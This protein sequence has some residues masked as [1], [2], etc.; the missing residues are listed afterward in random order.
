M[1][2]VRIVAVG[3]CLLAG[4]GC[5]STVSP[6][7]GTLHKESFAVTVPKR[8]IVKQGESVPVTISLNRD[9]FFK[10]NVQ[11]A[12]NTEGV[13][14]T[15]AEVLISANEVPEVQVQVSAPIDAALG[16][17]LIYVNATPTT[18]KATSTEFTAEVII[19]VVPDAL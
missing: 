1:K 15:P 10:R 17:Y 14:V 3:L 9:P 11:L 19:P 16:E 4:S 13:S 6:R 5:Q 2:A 12:I 8:C 18:G 7:G